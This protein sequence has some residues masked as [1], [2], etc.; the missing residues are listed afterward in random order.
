M[1]NNL[2]G[3]GIYGLILHYSIVFAIVGGTFIIFLYLWIQGLLSMDEEPKNSMLKSN[4]EAPYEG[5]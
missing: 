4:D 3:F 5:S 1:I 2:D